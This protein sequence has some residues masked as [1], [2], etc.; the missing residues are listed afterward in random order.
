MLANGTFLFPHEIRLPLQ[1]TAL[2]GLSRRDVAS[3]QS[4]L[5]FLCLFAMIG[6]QITSTRS[7]IHTFSAIRHG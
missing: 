6:N 2:D 5:G 7:A 4:S 1:R 3:Q